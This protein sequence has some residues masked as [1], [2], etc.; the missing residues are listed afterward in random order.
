MLWLILLVIPVSAMLYLFYRYQ[1]N[2]MAQ[3]VVDNRETQSNSVYAPDVQ[4]YNSDNSE[5]I[6]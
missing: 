6:N 4:G 5:K 2:S 1:Q 3:I